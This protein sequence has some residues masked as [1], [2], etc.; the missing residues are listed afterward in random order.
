MRVPLQ[1]LRFSPRGRRAAGPEGAERS[2]SAR[3]R[4]AERPSQ[5]ERRRRGCGCCAT[6]TPERGPGRHGP[7]RRHLRGGRRSGDLQPGD[8]VVVDEVTPRAGR[9]RT[10][11][12]RTGG[13]A[14]RP[15][16]RR[17]L[18]GHCRGAPIIEVRDVTK[19]YRL[20]DVEVHALRGVSLT[21][22]RGEFVAIMGASG[23]GKST[24]MNILGCL[25][26]PTSG[27]LPARGR[28]T[29]PALDEP[30]LARIRSR[31]IGF[32]FQSFNLLAR[33]SALENVALPLFYS[34]RLADSTGAGARGAASARPRGA[35]AQLPEPALGRPAAA[36]RDRARADQRP[37]HPA[38]RRADREPRLADRG[39]DH[40]D[41]PGAQ[42]RARGDRGAGHPR[43]RHGRLRRPRRSRCATG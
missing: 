36:R 32:V 9:Q 8:R 22:E 1:A 20:G 2:R 5:G 4:P 13:R 35:R 40:D 25:D 39:R 18:T 11:R 29:S 23:S 24:L 30:A 12:R 28:S 33:A 37:G 31:R 15:H 38:G 6:V 26:Q 43:A 14:P 17:L 10:A 19:I 42:P 7:E 21:V 34:G 3:A 27:Q 41:H 16:F